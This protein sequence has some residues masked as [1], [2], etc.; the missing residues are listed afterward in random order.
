MKDEFLHR[1]RKDPR[2]QFAARLQTRLRRQSTRPLRPRVPSRARTLLTLLLLGGT[3]FAVTFVAMRGL[4]G[5]LVELYQ[6]VAR[7]ITARSSVSPAQRSGAD[8]IREEWWW[9]TSRSGSVAGTMPRSGAAHPATAAIAAAPAAATVPVGAAASRLRQIPTVSSWA[10]YPYAVAMAERAGTFG[11]LLTHIDVS[12]A[13]DDWLESLC[14]GAPHSPDLAYTF[15]PVGTVSEHPCP[16]SASGAPSAVIA[17]PVGYE[18]VVLARSPLYGKID[19]TRREVFLMLAKWVPDPGR[20]GTLRENPNRTWRQIDAALGPE[21]IEIIGPSLSSAAG[22]SMVQ[23][24]LQGGCDT[25]PSIAALKLTDPHRHARICRTVRTDGVYEGSVPGL[26]PT[27]LLAE[28]N[29]IGILGFQAL[30]RSSVTDLAVSSLDGLQPS[31]QSIESGAYPGSRGLYLY[32]NRAQM[33]DIG[34]IVSLIDTSLLFYPDWAFVPPTR[35]ESRAALS[36]LSA[37]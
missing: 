35:A 37:P 26:A 10:A 34:L 16:R 21:P 1:L 11:A 9:G 8:K 5:P 24:L 14:H 25:V 28:P 7:R 6:Q 20:P 33:R 30:T 32:V 12:V 2:P 23:L 31:L 13:R 29:A 22:R 36:E 18:A 3:A 15:A 17:I 4:P 27:T 19:L